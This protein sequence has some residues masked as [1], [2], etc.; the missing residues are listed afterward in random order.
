MS[1]KK[2][3][4]IIDEGVFRRAKRNAAE[5]GKTLSE[6]IQE[7]L[8]AYTKGKKHDEK[9][10]KAA[11]RFFCRNPIKIDREDFEEILQEDGWDI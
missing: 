3:G 10:R 6:Y 9:E 5:E 7:A 2:I 1:K 4:T 11:Y 8:V